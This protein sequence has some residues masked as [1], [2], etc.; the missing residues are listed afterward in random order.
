M[1]ITIN[2]TIACDTARL[3]SFINSGNYDYNSEIGETEKS[4]FEK[5]MADFN[6]WLED[7]FNAFFNTKN[8]LFS[9]D[10]KMLYVWLVIGIL[11]IAALLYFMYRKRMFFFEKKK[12]EEEG[13]KVVEDTIYGID[14]DKDISRAIEAGNYREAIRLR[15]LQCLKWL[16]DNDAIDWRIHKTPAQYSREYKNEDFSFITRQYVLVRYGDYDATP[17]IYNAISDKYKTVVSSFSIIQQKGG[18]N[19][20]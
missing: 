14:F 5:V 8:D 12:K 11:V 1:N 4:V 10:S 7:L 13:Y 6:H 20:A 3:N 9:P 16:S 2:D 17:G 15:Y 18:D 19:E